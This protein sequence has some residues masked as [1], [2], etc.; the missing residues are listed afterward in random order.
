MTGRPLYMLRD[1]PLGPAAA[2]R[3]VVAL[4]H[5]H[6]TTA[7]ARALDLPSAAAGREA[8][9]AVLE[10][11]RDLLAQHGLDP[12]PYPGGEWCVVEEA[13]RGHTLTVTVTLVGDGDP[14]AALPVGAYVE[15]IGTEPTPEPEYASVAGDALPRPAAALVT[16]WWGERVDAGT[17]PRRREVDQPFG[18]VTSRGQ[19]LYDVILTGDALRYADA[20]EREAR[21]V[22]AEVE[23]ARARDDGRDAEYAEALEHLAD[24]DDATG[25]VVTAAA[26]VIRSGRARVTSATEVGIEGEGWALTTKPAPDPDGE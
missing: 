6:M 20:L 19:V 13:P 17:I 5:E 11:L 14:V 25:G 12:V 3:V 18:G 2:R 21:D 7:T 9:A 8:Q 26:Q 23:Q 24:A 4:E 22:R 1:Y 15:Q 16:A 10:V